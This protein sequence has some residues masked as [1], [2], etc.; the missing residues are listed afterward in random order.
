M[1]ERDLAATAL[2]EEVLGPRGGA[3]E[4]LGR[5]EDPLDEYITGVLA[6]RE[7]TSVD[8]DSEEEALG[9]DE[10]AA[11]DQA[12]PGAPV[13]ALGLTVPALDPR[14]RPASLG[15]SFSVRADRPVVDICCTWARYEQTPDGWRRSPRVGF[16]GT[17]DCSVATPF[18]PAADPDIELVV[19]ARHQEGIW[20]VSVFLVNATPVP[21]NQFPHT[22]Q[23]VF[24]P[25]IRIRC[26]DGIQL[27]PVDDVG[28]LRDPEDAALAFLYRRSRSMGRGHLCSA[29]WR[30]LD[31]ERPW[32]GSPASSA[33]RR[34]PFAWV[35]GEALLSVEQRDGFSPADVR[36][37]YVPADPRFSAVAV[38]GWRRAR[39]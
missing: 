38:L 3:W 4:I 12:D 20:R 32:A 5:D 1:A 35:D 30:A 23:H 18:R 29:V 21:P 26:R 24:Q 13:P 17:V 22:P 34:P 25:Q 14:S 7:S 31:P 6:P 39:A 16:W 8:L 10:T 28:E 36:T 33:P 2:I 15:L 19:R 9:E 11:D 27:V 37:E